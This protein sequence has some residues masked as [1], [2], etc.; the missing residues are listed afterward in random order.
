MAVDGRGFEL[1]FTAL[2]AGE[3]RGDRLEVMS[4][5]EHTEA[6]PA[7][8]GGTFAGSLP[9]LA[10]VTWEDFE[11]ASA[12]AQQD[13]LDGQITGKD[14]DYVSAAPGPDFGLGD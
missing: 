11:R 1:P 4:A 2:P 3:R 10:D 13:L 8:S 5:D 6:A 14:E 9:H 7:G 12:L